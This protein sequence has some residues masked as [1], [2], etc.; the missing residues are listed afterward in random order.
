MGGSK[1]QPLHSSW[2]TL[3]PDTLVFFVEREKNKS[4][5]ISVFKLQIVGHLVTV[6]LN[7]YKHMGPVGSNTIL[8]L[9][10]KLGAEKSVAVFCW[11]HNAVILVFWDISHVFLRR[12]HTFWKSL[13][14]AYS[15]FALRH[16]EW[17][18]QVT[19]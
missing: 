5:W 15:R 4:L 8:F 3:C 14:P 12:L 18:Q 9:L 11:R 16:W 17:G 10:R 6:H 7:S 19:T 13:F 1:I 2:F